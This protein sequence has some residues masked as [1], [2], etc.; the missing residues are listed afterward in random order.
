MVKQVGGGL[1][2]TLL[3]PGDPEYPENLR[4][5]GDAPSLFI[6]GALK[7]TD[8]VAVAV[9]GTRNPSTVGR[10]AAYEMASDLAR[11]GVTVVSGMAVGIDTSAHTGALDA[12]GRTLACLGAGIDVPYPA[13]NRRLMERVLGQGA[14]LSEYP[15]GSPPLAW[16]FPAR[17][18]IIAGLALG[19]LV[20]EAGEK[21]GALITVDWANKYGRPVMAVPGSVKN[22]ACRGS[23]KLLQDGA[24]VACSASDVLSFVGRETE[25]V[26]QGPPEHLIMD[27]TLEESL[28]LQKVGGEILAVEDIMARLPEMSPGCVLAAL[29]SLELKGGAKR[30]A[31]GAYSFCGR[32]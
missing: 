16:H 30:V 7:P 31:G 22:R 6:A 13:S 23:N 9:V 12:G 24:Y 14:L 18:R 15:P 5:V 17:N 1:P 29:S 27:L 3:G 26:P 4:Q 28:V 11:A 21:S 10:E 8:R 20:V 32:R 25:Y 2:E 19:V